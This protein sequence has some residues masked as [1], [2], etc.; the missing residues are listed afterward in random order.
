MAHRQDCL[1]SFED[2]H[3]LLVEVENDKRVIAPFFRDHGH[4][5]NISQSYLMAR[6]DVPGA[7]VDYVWE[8]GNLFLQ[9]KKALDE[10]RPIV[11]EKG[12]DESCLRDA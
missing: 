10:N 7:S 11:I 6:S 2:F 5:Y 3:R 1:I 9:T 8:T 4:D 12:Y